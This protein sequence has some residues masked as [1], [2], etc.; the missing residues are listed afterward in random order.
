MSPKVYSVGGSVRDMLLGRAPKDFDYVVVGADVQYMLDQGYKQVGSSFPVFLHP[1]SGSEYALARKEKKVAPGYKGFEFEFGPHVTLEEDLARRDLTINSIAYDFETKQYIDPF[2]GREDLKKGL[3]RHTSEAFAEDPL[4]ILRVAR[5]SARYQ[6]RVH[7]ETAML[8]QRLVL[9]LDALS[10]DRVWGE[11]EKLFSE[12]YP[13]IGL[14]FLHDIGALNSK[15]LDAI[16][17]PF[18]N[19]YE[20]YSHDIEPTLSSI[21][22]MRFS[23]RFDD[24][25]KEQLEEFRVPSNVVREWKFYNTIENLT[26]YNHDPE[27][28]VKSFDIYRA[29]IKAGD[30][31]KVKAFIFNMYRDDPIVNHY[32]KFFQHL[33]LAFSRLLDLDFTELTI[34]VKPSE[35][36]ELV[37]NKK[38]KI[39]E[40]AFKA[41]TIEPCPFC[42]EVPS[43]IGYDGQPAIEM[44]V[45][46]NCGAR[47]PSAEV[48]LGIST[49][50]AIEE[51][52]LKWNKRS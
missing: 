38:I 28:V 44:F 43:G 21:E 23:L 26:F 4:R 9:E 31:G 11:L 14:K 29:E 47:G 35:I 10:A 50:T 8:C 51:A 32:K 37:R 45:R 33:D 48:G 5:F 27:L 3:I 49:T 18:F 46:C 2:N 34:G 15:R 42:G 25:T 7:R 20:N 13:S 41:E 40:E 24:M 1:E 12:D 17:D 36:K 39:V 16:V 30:V 52:F 6:F 19:D 22:R